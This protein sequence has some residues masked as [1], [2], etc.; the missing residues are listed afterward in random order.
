MPLPEV[1][2][3]LSV[4]PEMTCILPL[5]MQ[6][7]SPAPEF[8]LLTPSIYSFRLPEAVMAVE[9]ILLFAVSMLKFFKYSSSASP[10]RSTLA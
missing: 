6:I 7:A 3:T 4:P 2:V 10:L 1:V 9:V 8:I 5:F